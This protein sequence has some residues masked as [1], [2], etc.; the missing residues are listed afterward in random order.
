MS[1]RDMSGY[2]IHRNCPNCFARTVPLTAFLT[3]GL[4]CSNCNTRLEAGRV[5]ALGFFVVTFLVTVVSTAAVM[6]TLGFYAGLLWLPFPIGALGYLKVRYCPF[7]AMGEE[8]GRH[9]A[10]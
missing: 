6:A 1:D 5:C 9:C 10:E 7:K 3:S 4:A 2:T 8:V